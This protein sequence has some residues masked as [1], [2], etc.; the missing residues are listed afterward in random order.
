VHAHHVAAVAVLVIR[1]GHVLALRRA[2][3]K[4][5]APG[6]WETLSG[7]IEPD[8]QPWEAAR[9]EAKE[10]TDMEIAVE[11]RPWTAYVAD[12]AGE[13]ML[14]VVYRAVP[15]GGRLRLSSEHDRHA[16]L[17]AEAFLARSPLHALGE[18]VRTALD[19]PPPDVA[20]AGPL[21]PDAG[22]E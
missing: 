9:R 15:I 22:Q 7:R 11:A 12:R 14:V 20:G 1:D 3:W 18:A 8:E 10:E 5:A 19:A 2:P 13:P 6:V 21:T 16:W 17:D 4:D